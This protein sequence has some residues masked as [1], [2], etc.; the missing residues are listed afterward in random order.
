MEDLMRKK[1]KKL[2]CER[3][4]HEAEVPKKKKHT[5]FPENQSRFDHNSKALLIQ[6]IAE[7]LFICNQGGLFI[8]FFHQQDLIS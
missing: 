1:R 3:Y 8:L 4:D 5:V 7:D 6:V 2:V